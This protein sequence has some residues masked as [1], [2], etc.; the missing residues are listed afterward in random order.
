MTPASRPDWTRLP[1]LAARLPLDQFP[2]SAAYDLR[3][4]MENLMGP[5]VLWLAETLTQVMPLRPG[6]GVLDM[7]CGRAI[8]SIF[9][10]RE[11]SVQVWATDLWVDA[12][13]NWQRVIAAG[14][15]DQ[16]CPIHAE[17]HALPF[18]D[19]FFDALVSLDAYHYFGTDD[20]YLGYYAR[21]LRPGGRIGMVVPGLTGEL[22]DEVPAHLLPY[23]DWD[24]CS[25]HSPQWWRH[26]W[27]KTGK[28]TVEVADLVPGGWQHW[29]AWDELCVE[30]GRAPTQPARRGRDRLRVH[31]GRTLGFTRVVALKP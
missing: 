6:M 25:F 23:W 15:Q 26:H 1:D 21:F 12:T 22:Q 29:K 9:L 2:R 31:A 14:S 18:A 19:G 24:M 16:V 5:N 8:S 30:L 4:V 3:W 28:V 11:F 13:E 7:G 27:A 10:A 17:A 20:L